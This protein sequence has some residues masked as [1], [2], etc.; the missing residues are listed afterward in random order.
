[1]R[2]LLAGDRLS[3]DE[4]GAYAEAMEPAERLTLAGVAALAEISEGSGEET[5]RGVRSG[6]G[7]SRSVS[8][9]SS[10]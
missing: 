3:D 9:S 7:A 4:A 6:E 2:F 1:M 5:A 8:S 10:S